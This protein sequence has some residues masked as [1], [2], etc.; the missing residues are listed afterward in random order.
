MPSKP[1]GNAL[2][3][4]QTDRKRTRGIEAHAFMSIVL[5]WPSIDVRWSLAFA[6]IGSAQRSVSE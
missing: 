5:A 6:N 2:D 4:E 3:S 1:P